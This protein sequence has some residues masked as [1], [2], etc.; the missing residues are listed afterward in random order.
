LTVAVVEIEAVDGV[1][2]LASGRFAFAAGLL[3]ATLSL[4]LA[5]AVIGLL[6]LAGVLP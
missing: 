3:A 4:L 2:R 6:A 5:P 1:E